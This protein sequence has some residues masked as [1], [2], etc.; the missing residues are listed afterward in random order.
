MLISVV[1][2]SY[3][4]GQYIKITIDSVLKQDYRNVEYLVSGMLAISCSCQ[5]ICLNSI[6]HIT[7]VPGGFPVTVDSPGFAAPQRAK[8]PGNHRRIRTI[9]I[10]PRTKHIE[11]AQADA[12]DAIAT[13]KDIGIEFIDQL[14]YRVRR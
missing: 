11:V 13:L 10:L 4:Q 1:T 6:V 2:P 5:D 8:P 3:N 14:G 12:I 9:G 7:E